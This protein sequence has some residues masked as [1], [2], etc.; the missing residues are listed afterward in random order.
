MFKFGKLYG[1]PYLT[2]GRVIRDHTTGLFSSSRTLCISLC[3]LLF[4]SIVHIILI[5]V[6]P[7]C[8]AEPTS[9]VGRTNPLPRPPLYLVSIG[10]L[11]TYKP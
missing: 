1:S 6:S 4:A 10:L 7:R 2:A 5:A 9:T 8:L 11:I 3:L